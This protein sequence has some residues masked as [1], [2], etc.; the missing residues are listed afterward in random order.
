MAASVVN[1]FLLFVQILLS[2]NLSKKVS[3]LE[4]DF[5]VIVPGKIHF[6]NQSGIH[7]SNQTMNSSKIK[8]INTST[9]GIIGSFFHYGTLTVLAEGD[10]AQTGSMT[11]NFVGH[12]NE[13][14]MEINKLL[15]KEL[16]EIEEG[17]NYFL[18]YVLSAM[19]IKSFDAAKVSG[20]LSE[21]ESVVKER[22]EKGS[23]HEREEI[24]ETYRM[25]ANV[26]KA[27]SVS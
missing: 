16:E 18:S 5:N 12:P 6:F 23:E 25:V 1:V 20:W 26:P 22:F 8:T 13:T 7:S 14:T 15:A 4:M 9:S 24:R 11:M 21:N 17:E 2:K 27:V 3:D 10:A 19:K